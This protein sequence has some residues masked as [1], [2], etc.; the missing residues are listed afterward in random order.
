MSRSHDVV[1]IGGGLAG[2]RAA[3]DLAAAG[4]SVQVLEARDRL[5]G[6]GWTST[7]PGT[8]ARVE[9]GG[10]WYTPHQPE[11]AAE[12]QRY[13][14]TV[15][16]FDAP[17]SVRWRT[18]DRLRTDRAFDADDTATVTGWQQLRADAEAACR[19]DDVERLRLPLTHYLDAIDATPTVRELA[20]GWWTITGGGR[21]DEGAAI[22]LADAGL[23][24]GIGDFTYLRY[25]PAEGW[26][27]LAEALADN[28]GVE[29]TREAAVSAVSQDADG[30][31]VQVGSQ[32]HTAGAASSRCRST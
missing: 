8:D 2:L 9:L 18:G 7:Y 14:L 3:R 32:T 17:T 22:S 10:G 27:A 16:T 30:V 26:T 23:H 6:R 15:R 11:V 24:G 1:V 25:A 29:V 19:G 4:L 13:G 5:G 31:R 20:Q 21:P 28:P 12:I